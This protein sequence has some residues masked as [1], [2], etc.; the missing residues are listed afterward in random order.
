[1]AQLRSGISDLPDDRP[2][3]GAEYRVEMG[4]SAASTIELA[5]EGADA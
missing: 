2:R 1:M 3:R 4:R 5:R